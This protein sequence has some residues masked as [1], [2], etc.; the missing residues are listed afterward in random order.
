MQWSSAQSYLSSMFNSRVSELQRIL[1]ACLASCGSFGNKLNPHGQTDLVIEFVRSYTQENSRQ[2][3][4]ESVKTNPAPGV[5]L[6]KL[7]AR[8]LPI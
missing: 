8:R 3:S 1:M 7:K 4:E 2:S 6:R 5:D